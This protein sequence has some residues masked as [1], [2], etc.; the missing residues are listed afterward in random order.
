MELWD[1]V[2]G[3]GAWGSGTLS[4]AKPQAP[5]PPTSSPPPLSPHF[6]RLRSYAHEVLSFVLSLQSIAPAIT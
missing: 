4:R 5:A 3:E 2:G 6:M 1:G